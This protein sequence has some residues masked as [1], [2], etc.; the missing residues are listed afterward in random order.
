MGLGKYK[1]VL[2]K[3]GCPR[4]WV[5]RSRSLDKSLRARIFVE[6]ALPPIPA[7]RIDTGEEGQIPGI[8]PSTG[9]RFSR[10]VASANHSGTPFSLWMVLKCVSLCM[11][12]FCFLLDLPEVSAQLEPMPCPVYLHHMVHW[13]EAG[14]RTGSGRK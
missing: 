6:L 3:L 7:V 2:I 10:V 5:P 4:K 12:S 14:R 1:N 9:V 8:R 11:D 13:L